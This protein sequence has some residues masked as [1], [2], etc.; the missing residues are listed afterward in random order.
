MKS[1]TLHVFSLLAVVQKWPPGV[2]K[3]MLPIKL[4]TPDIKGAVSLKFRGTQNLRVTLS[5][6]SWGVQRGHYVYL[7][8]VC[9]VDTLSHVKSG[10]CF[11][12]NLISEMVQKRV[13][14]I[15]C[16]CV[17]W[18]SHC[19]T[20]L[21]DE[22]YLQSIHSKREKW[23]WALNIKYSFAPYI[24]TDLSQITYLSNTLILICIF[25]TD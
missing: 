16:V 19:H 21:W 13:R 14:V 10:T 15:S 18:V 24:V 5:S 6:H 1:V 17:P 8:R 25:Q 2:L 7:L 9:V 22:R 11:L 3:N 20:P 23:N 4:I 12:T